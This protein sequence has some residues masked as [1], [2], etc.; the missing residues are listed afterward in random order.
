MLDPPLA[1]RPQEIEAQT[2]ARR[3]HLPHQARPGAAPIGLAPPRIQR[4]RIA[5][6]ARNPCRP[7]RC[8]AGAV[9]R[10]ARS[11]PHHS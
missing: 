3:I 5:P 1:R 8:A 11:P 4:P 9:P 10:P 7:A 6:A 2:I